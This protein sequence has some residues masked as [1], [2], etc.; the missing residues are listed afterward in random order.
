MIRDIVPVM[1]LKCRNKKSDG[2]EYLYCTSLEVPPL[3][4]F[5]P[6]GGGV[7]GV[8]CLYRN[9]ATHG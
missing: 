7:V 5:S 6:R 9:K 1:R 3:N 4:P 2:K 8:Y